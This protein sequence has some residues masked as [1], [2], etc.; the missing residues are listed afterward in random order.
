MIYCRQKTRLQ[1]TRIRLKMINRKGH[2]M[3]MAYE[4]E[5]TSARSTSEELT[6]LPSMEQPEEY[7]VTTSDV[8]ILGE[9]ALNSAETYKEIMSEVVDEEIKA[10]VVA[11]DFWIEFRVKNELVSQIF[12][13]IDA[14]DLQID[15][16]SV[17][18]VVTTEIELQKTN[19]ETA[20]S[21]IESS[22]LPEAYQQMEPIANK[23]WIK[24]VPNL[25]RR[26][27]IYT[28]TLQHVNNYVNS[29][30]DGLYSETEVYIQRSINAAQM[31]VIKIQA[32]LNAELE[33]EN[34]RQLN[35]N[36][37]L[38]T[39]LG[40]AVSDIEE[41]DIAQYDKELV[42]FLTDEARDIAK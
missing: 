29:S 17:Q 9:D 34:Q 30:K 11:L 16:S 20:V 5:I 41:R 40:Q 38:K 33:L 1:Q 37:Q 42:D 28:G 36:N 22:S 35:E 32:Q 39:K 6:A 12:S 24:D 8:I 21:R 3:T 26:Q 23:Y 10:E 18:D 19:L 4:N 2:R 25:K 27:S 14:K 31:E 7:K 15:I 13:N